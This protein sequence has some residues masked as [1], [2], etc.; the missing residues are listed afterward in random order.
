MSFYRALQNVLFTLENISQSI[1]ETNGFKAYKIRYW[2]KVEGNYWTT[3]KQYNNNSFL[4]IAENRS[5]WRTM[6]ANVYQK[7]LTALKDL[8]SDITNRV[9]EHAKRPEAWE[10]LF[11]TLNIS[12]FFLSTIKNVSEEESVFTDVEIQTLEKAINETTKWETEMKAEQIAVPLTEK[13][14]VTVYMIAE[15]INNLDREIKYLL[16]KS[17]L[18]T[19][20]S[21]QG[22]K[23]PTDSGKN[24]TDSKESNKTSESEK[25]ATS[26]KSDSG[27]RK[28][29]D[30]PDS[31]T[32]TKS[33]DTPDSKTDS[34]S[35][36]A[37]DSKTDTKSEDSKA[38]EETLELPG[39]ETATDNSEDKKSSETSTDKTPTEG[40][41]G[42]L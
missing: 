1:V 16:S 5:E 7:K 10:A 34:K 6:I 24:K 39:P 4:R 17:K 15:K 13:P 35:E 12:R 29:E 32:D 26:N 36:D 30:D 37:P 3:Q 25:E 41:H 9:K 23:P 27:D 31:K 18:A 2:C 21:K 19:P 40:S 8:T 11:N 33:E 14:K 20:K 28:A 22:N 38:T 42:E